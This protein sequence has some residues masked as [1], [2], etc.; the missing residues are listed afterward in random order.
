MI[1]SNQCNYLVSMERPCEMHLIFIRFIDLNFC[2]QYLLFLWCAYYEHDF[3]IILFQILNARNRLETHWKR[4]FISRRDCF[5]K[6]LGYTNQYKSIPTSTLLFIFTTQSL[7]LMID[8]IIKVQN[9]RY[10]CIVFFIIV[11]CSNILLPS[12]SRL[13]FKCLLV[14]QTLLTTYKSQVNCA[15]LTNPLWMDEVKSS[16]NTGITRIHLQT[17]QWQRVHGSGKAGSLIH[18]YILNY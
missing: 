6:T 17:V 13:F 2:L 3:T 12:Y 14:S 11:K 9:L 7:Q 5:Q 15:C 4:L 10:K 16:H 8:F 1:F 18:V